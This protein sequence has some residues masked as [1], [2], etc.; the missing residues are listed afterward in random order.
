MIHLDE[1]VRCQTCCAALK[2]GKDIG[3]ELHRQHAVV[4]AASVTASPVA[5]TPRPIDKSSF[6]QVAVLAT[7][8]PSSPIDARAG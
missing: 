2:V 5:I 3:R 6:A 7:L 4:T 1:R 8:G